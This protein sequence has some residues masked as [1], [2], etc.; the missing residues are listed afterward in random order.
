MKK[1]YPIIQMINETVWDQDTLRS[2]Y[3]YAVLIG[4]S[5]LRSSVTVPDERRDEMLIRW[6]AARQPTRDEMMKVAV[7]RAVERLSPR[8][9]TLW[10]KVKKSQRF[11][12]WEGPD[13]GPKA[14]AELEKAGL[15][16][17]MG[18][19]VSIKRCWVPVGTE[20]FEVEKFPSW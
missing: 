12:R 17:S 15:V 5:V 13:S 19:V 1:T 8:G 7:E 16:G 18:R 3:A 2:H 9:R 20:P 11:F 10:E 4:C 14:M 6:W